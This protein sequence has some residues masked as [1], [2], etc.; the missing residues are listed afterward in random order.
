MPTAASRRIRRSC[1]ALLGLCALGPAPGC[2]TRHAWD[3]TDRRR[4]VVLVV[5]D[6]LRADHV[7]VYGA[8][9]DTTPHL[10]RLAHRGRWLETA[11][12][13]APW[14]PPSVMSILTSVDPVVHG[15]GRPADRLAELRVRPAEGLRT[16]AQVLRERGWRTQAVTGGGAVSRRWGFE[17]GFE[18]F[19][20][21]RPHGDEDVAAGV[22]RGLAWLLALGREQRGFLFLHTYEPHLPHTHHLFASQETGSPAERVGAAYDGDVAFAD[23]ELGRLFDGL[24]RRGL[25]DRSVV[26]VTSDHG[27]NLHDRANGGRPVEHGHH[28]HDELLRVPLI[29]VAPGLVPPR[30]RLAGPASSL[31]V[32]P[33]VLS[34]LGLGDGLPQ[35]QGQDLRAALQG[36]RQLDPARALFAG[37][38]L[39]GPT[40]KAVR[41]GPSKLV[42]APPVQGV[43]WWQQVREPAAARYD[44]HADPAELSPLPATDAESRHLAALLEERA[45]QQAEL[46]AR[47]GRSQ[48]ER[49]SPPAEELAALGYLR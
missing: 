44:L 36:R 9:R 28:L 27:E 25:L 14:T 5:I 45:R 31:D 30:G 17:R 29:V 13:A 18:G 43:G 16:L 35:A 15:L 20:E 22:D 32:A 11:W 34:L 8:A 33:T 21:P 2:G 39:Q 38:T 12:S 7:G 4:H 26:V 23:R 3:R 46:V 40:W 41:S 24:E 19:E 1:A 10:D 48:V 37:A 6:T 47:L 42:L 49:F